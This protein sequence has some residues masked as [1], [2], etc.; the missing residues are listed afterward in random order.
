MKSVQ[1]ASIDL[2]AYADR[3]TI[4]SDMYKDISS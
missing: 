2:V 1:I 4:V 3:V